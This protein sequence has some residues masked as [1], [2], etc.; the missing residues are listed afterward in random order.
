MK[1]V[2]VL[3]ALYGALR[4]KNNL[5][6]D[7]KVL[8]RSIGTLNNEENLFK[9]V[10]W[11]IYG[12]ATCPYD[13]VIEFD[14]KYDENDASE[15]YPKLLINNGYIEC[16]RRL[17]YKHDVG[18]AAL[19]I[20]V[21]NPKN[22]LIS[23]KMP[24]NII[25]EAFDGSIEFSD[26]WEKYTSAYQKK[27]A[28]YE[29]FSQA[30]NYPNGI[31][32]ILF[33]SSLESLFVPD[34]EKSKKRDFVIQGAKILGFSNKEQDYLKDLFEYRNAYIH[35]DKKK[36]LSLLS[37]PKFTLKWYEECEEVIRKALFNHVYKSW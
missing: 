5:K 25:F 28:A 32:S 33:C 37:G 18:F 11:R 20:D 16:S 12:R 30:L 36:Q 1:K 29:Y 7:D 21:N 34:D 24:S 8:V 35:A 14:Y 15:P 9:F 31:K 27:P 3:L 6:L 2:K 10:N 17:F 13:W 19:A 22:Y 23:S 26:F 4:L